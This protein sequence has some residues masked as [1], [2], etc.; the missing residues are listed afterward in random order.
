[1]PRRA[2]YYVE[3]HKI[4][5]LKT[6][7]GKEKVLLNGKK[8]SEKV[9]EVG[10]Q[11]TFMIN[12]N[13]YRIAPRESLQAQKMSTYEIRKDGA[14]VALVNSVAQNSIQMFVLIIVVGLGS[15]FIFG[16]LLYNF[17]F[18]ASV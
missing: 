18:P 6:F 15:G 16:V 13:N 4:E 3:N 14:P 8:V 17:F 10:T 2:L 11:H 12:Q 7:F 9:A 5:I 1:M